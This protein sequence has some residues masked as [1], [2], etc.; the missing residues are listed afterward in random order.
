VSKARVYVEGASRS[1]DD[2]ARTYE[3]IENVPEWNTRPPEPVERTAKDPLGFGAKKKAAG[4]DPYSEAKEAA[5]R[6]TRF[7]GFC[8]SEMEL[9]AEQT[10]FAVEL[11]AL[12][13]LNAQD[14][15]VKG[16]KIEQIR[17][18]AFQYYQRSLSKIP[19]PK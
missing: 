17:Q 16:P 11:T 8:A 19:D 9:A 3:K 7:V 5:V 10:I 13:T 14:C 12:N 1:V 2:L 18:D 6:L 4:G 15:P